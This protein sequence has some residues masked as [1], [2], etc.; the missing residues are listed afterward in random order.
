MNSDIVY[1]TD[2]ARMWDGDKYNVRDRALQKNQPDFLIHST[3]DF[4][5]WL[6]TSP[7]SNVLMITT[8]PQ[9]WTNSRV[10]WVKELVLQTLKNTVKGWL[11]RKRNV[12]SD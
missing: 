6:N 1:L 3:M 2:T 4:I 9:R 5:N 11:V 10:G 8:H 12:V 7:A